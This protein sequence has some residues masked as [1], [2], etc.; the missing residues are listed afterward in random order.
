M[1]AS[2]SGT[3]GGMA[4]AHGGETR[5]NGLVK[6][7]SLDQSLF[8][9]ADAT[10][11]DLIDYLEAVTDPLLRELAGRPLSVMR[12][13]PGQQPFMQKNLPDYAP[14]FVASTTVWSE[15]GH[16]DIRY[17][18]CENRATLLW[19]G[20]QRAV[21]FHPTL[22]VPEPGERTDVLAGRVTHLVID[23][24]PPEGSGFEVVV[25]SARL[26]EQALAELSLTSA[27]K[28]SGSKGMHIVIPVTGI[29]LPDAAAATRALAARA[30]R[31]GPDIATTA[32]V[33]ADRGGKVFLDSTRAGGG[34]LASA[35]SPRIRPG[36]TVSYPV[37]WA[38][39]E[40]IAP[41]DFTIKTVPPMIDSDPWA[42]LLPEPQSVP[43]ELIAEGHSIP[44]ARVVAMH[45]GKRRKRAA[46]KAA[47]S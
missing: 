16:R 46:D 6:L 31:F 39:L 36:V 4:K 42:D 15:S 33:K 43:A 27:V 12:V 35:F 5:E 3:V 14:D 45:E 9:G 21:E 18:L 17:P 38:D 10:K 8:D 34:S 30:E 28:T 47:D 11:R 24:D 26:V 7:T 2:P 20:N 13:R 37:Q 25:A 29:D 23:L 44:V 22:M 32:Y 1:P 40:Q 41:A 19:F